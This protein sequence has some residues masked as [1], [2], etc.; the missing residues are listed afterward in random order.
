M[1]VRSDERRFGNMLSRLLLFYF[2]NFLPGFVQFVVEVLGKGRLRLL[3]LVIA[4]V[5]FSHEVHH[6]IRALFRHILILLNLN[7]H[8]LRV[9]IHRV[10][11]GWHRKHIGHVLLLLSRRLVVASA[12]SLDLVHLSHHL[13]HSKHLWITGHHLL[14]LNHHVLLDFTLHSWL[15]LVELLVSAIVLTLSLE[16]VVINIYKIL[17]YLI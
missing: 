12:H 14:H 7:I 2:S 3:F 9:I 1:R 13:H 11:H 4:S 8:L 10:H 5:H 17:V 15:W 16:L 6:I